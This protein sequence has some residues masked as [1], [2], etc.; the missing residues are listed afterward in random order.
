MKDALKT[1]SEEYLG[2]K[3]AKAATAAPTAPMLVPKP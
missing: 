2:Y 3:N 1:R